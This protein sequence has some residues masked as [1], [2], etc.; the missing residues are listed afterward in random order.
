MTAALQNSLFKKY[1]KI[2]GQK[3]DSIQGSC[4][5]WGLECGDGWYKLLD[6]LCYAI[7]KH[8]DE[9]GNFQVEASQVKEKFGTLSFYVSGAD[10]YVFDLIGKAEDESAHICE[11]CGSKEGVTQSEGWIVTLCP[12]CMKKYKEE[13]GLA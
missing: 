5:P 2:F 12:V 4:M 3:D 7:Q 11:E 8:C 6:D 1:A 9:P 10:D 13:R